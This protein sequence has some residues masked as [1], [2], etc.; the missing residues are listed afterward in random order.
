MRIIKYKYL[1]R[2]GV[3]S[4]LFLV[5]RIC[6][7]STWRLARAPGDPQ[8]SQR[9]QKFFLP[10][11]ECRIVLSAILF[12]NG[13]RLSDTKWVSPS[14]CFNVSVGL[15]HRLRRFCVKI[16][17]LVAG[18]GAWVRTAGTAGI[19]VIAGGVVVVRGHPSACHRNKIVVFFV[20]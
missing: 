20:A 8:I 14:Q 13:I 11:T 18:I 17:P 4:H 10:T 12:V 1:E 15:M 5:I 3:W 6:I 7:S 2:E 16:L 19:G 9:S